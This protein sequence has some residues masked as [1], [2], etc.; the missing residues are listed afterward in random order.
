M[1][2]ML[3]RIFMCVTGSIR[4]SIAIDSLGLLEGYLPPRAL[5]L[6]AEWGALHRDELKDDWALAEQRAQLKKIKPLE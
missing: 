2:T 5:G 6:I 1:M 4:L 3:R